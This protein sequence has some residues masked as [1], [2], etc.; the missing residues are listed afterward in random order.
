ML[1][2]FGA[3]RRFPGV[4]EA[5]FASEWRLPGSGEYEVEGAGEA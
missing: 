2:P 1:V 5:L 4:G 3:E